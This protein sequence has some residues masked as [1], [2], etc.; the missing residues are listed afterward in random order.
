MRCALTS[1]PW[2]VEV[3]SPSQLYSTFTLFP[4]A[5]SFCRF[6]IQFMNSHPLLLICSSY[7]PEKSKPSKNK[8]LQT[9]P[10]FWQPTWVKGQH[11]HKEQNTQRIK[12]MCKCSLVSVFPNSCS[13][14]KKTEDLDKYCSRFSLISKWP[15]SWLLSPEL[16]RLCI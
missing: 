11:K 8:T 7:L 6:F 10:F 3:K 4:W 5:S 12:A 14:W 13:A 2:P 16:N 9:R 15:W 1:I